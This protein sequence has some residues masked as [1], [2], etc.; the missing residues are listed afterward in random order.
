MDTVECEDGALVLDWVLSDK[1]FAIV[2]MDNGIEE[3]GSVLGTRTR[4]LDYILVLPAH[5]CCLDLPKWS[6]MTNESVREVLQKSLTKDLSGYEI[7][8]IRD[9]EKPNDKTVADKPFNRNNFQCAKHRLVVKLRTK[10]L[11][12]D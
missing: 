10:R 12:V 11:S 2:L 6:R 5:I 3:T 8:Y 4:C 9:I 1:D 7:D